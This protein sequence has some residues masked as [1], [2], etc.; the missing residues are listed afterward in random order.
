LNLIT[1]TPNALPFDVINIDFITK[2]PTS[3]G[4]DSIMTIVDHDC[5]KATIF[6]PC[7]EQMDVL[8]TAE[9][10]AKHVFPHYGLPQ[11]IIS[12]R[13]VWFTSTFTKELCDILKIKQNLSSAYHLQTDGLAEH[14]NQW[15]EQYLWIFGNALQ[16]DWL[17]HLPMAQF[18]HNS[19]PHEVTKQS[20][21]ELLIG[22][23]PQTTIPIPAQKVPALEECRAYLERIRW[24]AQKAMIHAQQLMKQGKG[25]RIFTLYQKNQKVWLEA[26]NLKATHPTTKLAPRRYGPFVVKN[27][28]SSIVYQLNI[29][30][31][32]KIHDI[33]HTS[34]LSPY[35][36]TTM[37]G[38]N[39]EEPPPEL[40]DEQPEWEVEAILDSRRFGCAK[41]LQ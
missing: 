33:F 31:H 5:T 26:T 20:P 13:D 29:P 11:R 4:F 30:K 12:D 28:I 24:M 6:I 15:V 36:E 38:P 1:T 10:Y 2:L 16:N 18:I 21:F 8:G 14:T 7:K 41:K 37:H 40:I 3:N 22:A 23:N 17:E 9:L 39:Y 35:N 34:L 27:V 19:W 32:W 25:K